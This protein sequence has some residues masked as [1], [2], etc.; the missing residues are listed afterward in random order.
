MEN[1]LGN[2]LRQILKDAGASLIGYADMRPLSSP[3]GFPTGIAVAVPVPREIVLGI[4]DGPTL[5]YN[6][7]YKILNNKLDEIITAGAN[8]L[9]HKGYRAYA[10]T[11]DVVSVN[12]NQE[13]PLPHKTVATM[14][15]LG[16]IGKSCILVTPEYGSAVRISSF[17]TDAPLPYNTPITKSNCGSCSKCVSAC[18]AHALTGTLWEAGMPREEFLSQEICYQTQKKLMLA[19][20]ELNTDLCGKCFVVCPYTRRYLRA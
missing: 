11:T 2:Q 9:E 19:R 10:Q 18:P 17:L 13:S 12:A 8:F 3:F 20:T 4:E 16:W 14:A 5:E 15:G 6:E 1:Q 7:M